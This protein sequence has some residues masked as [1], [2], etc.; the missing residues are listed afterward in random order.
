MDVPMLVGL[1]ERSNFAPMLITSGPDQNIW[2][3]IV[4]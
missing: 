2:F 1:N 3:E 4:N